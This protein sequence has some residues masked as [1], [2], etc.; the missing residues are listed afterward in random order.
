MDWISVSLKLVRNP[1]RSWEWLAK[2]DLTKKVRSQYEDP[3]TEA[4]LKL[5]NGTRARLAGKILDSLDE[6]VW[7]EAMLEGA[8]I[9]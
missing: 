2:W 7:A 3:A 6:P 9:P 1:L 5:P 4:A 8:K